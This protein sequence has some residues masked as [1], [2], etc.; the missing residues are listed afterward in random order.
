METAGKLEIQ[1]TWTGLL[2]T[3]NTRGY[4]AFGEGETPSQKQKT[5]NRK[6]KLQGRGNTKQ[7]KG[8]HKT[9]CWLSIEGTYG[10]ITHCPPLRYSFTYRLEMAGRS[11]PLDVVPVRKTCGNNR[12]SMTK[13][14]MFS[15]R[16]LWRK[17]GRMHPSTFSD[18]FFQSRTLGMVGGWSCGFQGWALSE[19]C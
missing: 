12:M 7:G 2:R 19:V 18:V 4:L 16:K 6:G 13:I 11:D 14:L 9:H 5:P 10:K 8:K 17:Y 15:I 1:P 3:P